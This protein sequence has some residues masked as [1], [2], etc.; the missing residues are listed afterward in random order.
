MRCDSSSSC[1]EAS[2]RK[3][4]LTAPSGT[5]S[6]T[7]AQ[8]RPPTGLKGSIGEGPNH[9]NFS[10]QSSVKIQCILLQKV[11]HVRKFKKFRQLNQFVQ[12]MSF[13]CVMCKRKIALTPP[14]PPTPMDSY[15]SI[16]SP[17]KLQ[18]Q[19][20]PTDSYGLNLFAIRLKKIFSSTSF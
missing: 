8:L 10:D 14:T 9:S 5:S 11:L 1:R 17:F 2:H 20:T 16:F 15:G 13:M 19:R 7:R 12:F 6:E 3:S 18:L 4:T